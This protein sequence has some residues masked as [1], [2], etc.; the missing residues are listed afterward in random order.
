MIVPQIGGVPMPVP[1]ATASPASRQSAF[2]VP[3]V[4]QEKVTPSCTES[5]TILQVPPLGRTLLLSIQETASAEVED[6]EARQHGRQMLQVLADLQREMLLGPV[7]PALTTLRMLADL[8]SRPSDP[9][10]AHV[11]RSIRLRARLELAR[12]AASM[13]NGPSVATDDV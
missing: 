8:D 1:A 2:R 3:E 6:R 7:A 5:P 12:A 13:N 4:V 10:L 11:I 9:A